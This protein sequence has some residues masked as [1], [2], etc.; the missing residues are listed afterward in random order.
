MKN[1]TLQLRRTH[2]ERIDIRANSEQE[3]Y[4]LAL[5]GHG[6]N[7]LLTNQRTE[8]LSIAKKEQVEEERRR[9]LKREGNYGSPTL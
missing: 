7:K 9:P 1:Y 2:Y 5:T 6:Q 3:A 8:L 4:Y